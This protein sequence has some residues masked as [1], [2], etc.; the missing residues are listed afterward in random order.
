[1][2]NSISRSKW[3]ATTAILAAIASVLFFWEMPVPL[4]PTFIQFDF[5]LLPCLIG[6][7]ALGPLSG[8]T[9]ALFKDLIHLIFKGFGATGGIGDMADFFVCLCMI[10]PFSLIYKKIPNYKGL[11]LGLAVGSVVSGFFAGLVL[12]AL[13]V[14]PLYDK[15]L[16]PMTAIIGMYQQIRPSS[17][18]LW[19][20]LAIF[21]MPYTFLKCAIISVMAVI[22]A[23]PLQ[24][25]LVKFSKSPRKSD[26]S[27][28]EKDIDDNSENLKNNTEDT[29]NASQDN[30]SE[31]KISDTDTSKN[32]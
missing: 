5:S 31:T 29:Q 14:Y 21:N 13:I 32:N 17:N 22:I 28:I 19:E 11:I 4:M 23:K 12:N 15:F 3:L 25:V 18:G 7:V 30:I 8:I 2:N 10:L 24:G 20:V 26:S 16:L 6:S 27:N 1:M 9:I